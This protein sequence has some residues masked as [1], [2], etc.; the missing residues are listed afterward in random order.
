MVWFSLNLVNG[1]KNFVKNFSSYKDF[2]EFSILGGF[3]NNPF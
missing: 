3:W 2:E 1:K